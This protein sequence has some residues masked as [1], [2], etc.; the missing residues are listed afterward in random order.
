MQVTVFCHR[1]DAFFRNKSLILRIDTNIKAISI[2]KDNKD[3]QNMFLCS[4][5]PSC[6]HQNHVLKENNGTK[7]SSLRTANFSNLS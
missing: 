2:C 7:N 5:N 4:Q 6:N 3:L 1:I